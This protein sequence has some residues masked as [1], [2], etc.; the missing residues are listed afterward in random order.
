MTQRQVENSRVHLWT[1]SPV[2]VD[3]VPINETLV[4]ICILIQIFI[5]LNRGLSSSNC[6]RN[7]IPKSPHIVQKIVLS[8]IRN[9][10]QMTHYKIF[11]KI[12]QC[13]TPKPS[14]KTP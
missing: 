3:I 12:F 8:M 7:N 11:E 4:E 5:V 6:T 13:F 10:R 2:S 9:I 14:E 1:F